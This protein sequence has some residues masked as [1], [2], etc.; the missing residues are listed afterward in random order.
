MTTKAQIAADDRAQAI[1][2]LNEFLRPG[3]TV[4]TV[5]RHVSA[6]GMSRSISLVIAHAYPDGA[7]PIPFDISYWC[8]RALGDRMDANH[9]G[10]KIS[11]CGMDMGFALVYNLG[12]VLF[13]DGYALDHHW[14]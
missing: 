14:L 4:T 13:R 12:H 8:A 5:L 3:D 11:G 6:S 9:G 7:T 1:E 2:A 10:I